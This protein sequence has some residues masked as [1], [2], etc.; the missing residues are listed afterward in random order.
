MPKKICAFGM[1][2]FIIPMMKKFAAEGCLPNFE[3]LLK[4]GVVLERTA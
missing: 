2:G 1:D 4:E 3:R